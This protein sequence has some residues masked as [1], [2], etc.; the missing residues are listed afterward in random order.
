MVIDNL[1]VCM[2]T[3]FIVQC[4]SFYPFMFFQFNIFFNDLV[5]IED[6]LILI[7]YKNVRLKEK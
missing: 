7:S 4:F 5:I 3:H 6:K 1:R 2:R